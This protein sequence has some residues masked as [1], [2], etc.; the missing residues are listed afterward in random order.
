MNRSC[1]FLFV[2]LVAACVVVPTFADNQLTEEEKKAG[3]KLLFNGKDLSGWKCNNGK[4]IATP[5]E[6]GSLVP[7]KSGGYIIVHKQPFENF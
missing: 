5:V 1:T 4:E 2:W 7:Y 3:W 6:Q